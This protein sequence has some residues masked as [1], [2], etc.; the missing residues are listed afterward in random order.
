MNVNHDEVN[1]DECYDLLGDEIKL[2]IGLILAILAIAL[3]VGG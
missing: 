3:C 2:F 1:D